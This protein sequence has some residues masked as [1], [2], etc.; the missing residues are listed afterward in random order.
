LEAKPAKGLAF[1]ARTAAKKGETT[2]SLLR[3]AEIMLNKL[4]LINFKVLFFFQKNNF[5]FLIKNL[6]KD[7]LNKETG[8]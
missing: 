7:F 2:E 6:E 1:M 8:L 4:Q 3:K 5:L